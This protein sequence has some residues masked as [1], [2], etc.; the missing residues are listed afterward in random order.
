MRRKK[1]PALAGDYKF[2]LVGR[3]GEVMEAWRMLREA[4]FQPYDAVWREDGGGWYRLFVR[5]FRM[6]EAEA[7][8]G[9]IVGEDVPEVL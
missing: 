8:L 5:G 7:I 1:K 2:V 9:Q 4:G 6:R 3:F